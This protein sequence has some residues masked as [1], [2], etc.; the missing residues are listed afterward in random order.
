M[1]AKIDKFFSFGCTE[2]EE[3]KAKV[4]ALGMK[5]GS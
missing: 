1:I 5:R 2:Y 4:A 3:L